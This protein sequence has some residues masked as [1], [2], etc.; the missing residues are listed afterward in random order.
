MTDIVALENNVNIL[1]KLLDDFLRGELV[2]PVMSD[3]IPQV[4]QPPKLKLIIARKWN[5]WYPCYFSTLGGCYAFITRDRNTSVKDNAGVIVIDPGVKFEEILRKLY[6]IEPQYIRNV[7][8]S[9][10]HPDHT[11][12]L[13]ELLTLNHES[14]YPC[15][16]YLN[17]TSFDHF[18]VFQGKHSKIS[19][20]SD[21][22][23]IK[24]AD[25]EYIDKPYRSS[26]LTTITDD[27][28]DEESFKK[29]SIYMRALRAFH[30]EVGSR[31][32]CLAF[33]IQILSED[34]HSCKEDEAN[35]LARFLHDDNRDSVA[36]EDSSRLIRKNNLNTREIVILGDT[37]GNDCYI[38]TYLDYL[39]NAEIAILHLGSFS[40]K[41]FGK[42]NK[43]LYKNGLLNI[44]NCINCKRGSYIGHPIGRIESCIE[45]H[46]I[47]LVNGVPMPGIDQCL[48][49]RDK[50]FF[51]KLKLVII[52]ELGLE[53]ASIEEFLKSIEGVKWLTGFYPLFLVSKLN[54][55]DD[56]YL[57][58]MN[59]YLTKIISDKSYSDENYKKYPSI[60]FSIKAI[61]SL[62]R[63]D[64]NNSEKGDY[65]P[66]A[67]Y[68][69]TLF[70][71]SN[72]FVLSF[73]SEKKEYKDIKEEFKQH[74]K[75]V[76][77]INFEKYR[78]NRYSLGEF[79]RIIERDI[80]NNNLNS[81]IEPFSLKI[82]A[83][84]CSLF[85]TA[86]SSDDIC[87]DGDTKLSLETTKN[88]LLLFSSNLYDYL[89]NI[90][91]YDFIINSRSFNDCKI[92]ADSIEM[93]SYMDNEYIENGLE[94][95]YFSTFLKNIYNDD[96]TLENLVYLLIYEINN[97]ANQLFLE[98]NKLPVSTHRKFHLCRD[99]LEIT[100]L[101]SSKSI[102]YFL[103]NI[104]MEI[105]FGRHLRIKSDEDNSFIDIDKSTQ[106]VK[107][108]EL[109]IKNQFP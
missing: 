78:K 109:K 41:S 52:S 7:I 93:F 19:E 65:I 105:E 45:N 33:S 84:L 18:K 102:K 4:D 55:K 21:G 39:K 5:S 99:L 16:Y 31:H 89:I 100:S 51:N 57:R 63:L 43:H 13:Y 81:I 58:S 40:N 47:R 108:G 42:G 97:L 107:N 56:T 12:G 30:E 20:I 79:L 83:F 36:Q 3:L 73:F 64:C 86:I 69:T 10:Y 101:Y 32:N 17:P 75:D 70:L 53:M 34:N 6:N 29:E 80:D 46:R 15:S 104:G 49:H 98:F 59:K 77:K 23:L 96:V 106:V 91:D 22:Q 90:K 44:M 25:Y 9:H 11:M 50:D 8:V 48:I 68:C 82:R 88:A 38:D 54:N 66:I 103:S 76:S 62:I 92:F 2:R 71:S 24:I 94:D 67:A 60:I 26:N 28:S 14:Q 61:E 35:S 95:K 72:L 87:L 85:E 74:L 27:N 37:D 1:S